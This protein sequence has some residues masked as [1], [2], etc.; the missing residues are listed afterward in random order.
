MT[1]LKK[2]Q[3]FLTN[4]HDMQQSQLLLALQRFWVLLWPSTASHRYLQIYLVWKS[5]SKRGHQC[6]SYGKCSTQPLKILW[7]IQPDIQQLMNL[8]ASAGKTLIN[9]SR[10]LQGLK[11]QKDSAWQNFQ[12][13]NGTEISG[14][15]ISKYFSINPIS[16]LLTS[17]ISQKKICS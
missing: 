11:F 6:L 7:I 10:L 16:H 13:H 12:K 17:M 15:W 14:K 2:N 8:I 5:L 4:E 9:P 1:A 3:V